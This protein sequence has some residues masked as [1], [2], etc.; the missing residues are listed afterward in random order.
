MSED[1][2]VVAVVCIGSRC[3]P[4]CERRAADECHP[5]AAVFPMALKDAGEAVRTIFPV[6]HAAVHGEL[7][8]PLADKGRVLL[9][10]E[11]AAKHRPLRDRRTQDE[12]LCCARRKMDAPIKMRRK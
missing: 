6:D 2:E 3:C 1:E 10:L 5:A 7:R 11:D 12:I 4:V 9:H 8:P